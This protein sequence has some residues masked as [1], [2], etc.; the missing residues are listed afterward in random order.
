[1]RSKATTPLV[2]TVNR[3]AVCVADGYR[4]TVRV[5]HGRL[6]VEDGFGPD[7]RRRER[8]RRAGHCQLRRTCLQRWHHNH[9]IHS[10]IV[11]RWT[12]R[13]RDGQ[14]DHGHGVNERDRVHV[15]GHGD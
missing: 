1:M 6:I 9:L 5:R 3:G 14:P 15:H 13:E 7:R 8:G 2:Y 10:H 12:H 11:T 4:V